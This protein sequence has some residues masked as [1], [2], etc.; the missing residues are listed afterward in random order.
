M[1][2]AVKRAGSKKGL[3]DVAAKRREIRSSSHIFY[4][5]GIEF[6]DR[7]YGGLP[8]HEDRIRGWCEA[9]GIQEALD[10]LLEIANPKKQVE[11]IVG[12]SEG[13]LVEEVVLNAKGFAWSERWGCCITDLMVKANLKCAMSRLAYFKAKGTMG[14]KGVMAEC[15]RVWPKMIPLGEPLAPTG[16]DVVKGKVSN[17]K[18]SSSIVSYVFYCGRD[19]RAKAPVRVEYVIEILDSKLVSADMLLT[20]LVEGGNIGLGA[21]RSREMGKYVVQEFGEISYDEW[22][23]WY[24][25]YRADDLKPVFRIMEPVEEKEE[26]AA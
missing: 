3:V 8:L 18:G 5:V 12:E 2:R 13:E 22:E 4:R 1:K 16:I 25:E 10:R 26:V 11:A 21:L 9:R 24:E 15:S 23:E 19:E 20:G 7:V 6:E 14:S 17:P